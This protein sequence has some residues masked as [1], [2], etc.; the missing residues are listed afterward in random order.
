MRK[1]SWSLARNSAMF[2]I[3]TEEPSMMAEAMTLEVS[4]VFPMES[5]YE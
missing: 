4:H 1:F 3:E 5:Q 2:L